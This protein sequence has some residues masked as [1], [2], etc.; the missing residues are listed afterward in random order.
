MET[1]MLEVGGG[2]GGEMGVPIIKPL[3]IPLSEHFNSCVTVPGNYVFRKRLEIF[4][5]NL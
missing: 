3:K 5:I 1:V 4:L 2:K